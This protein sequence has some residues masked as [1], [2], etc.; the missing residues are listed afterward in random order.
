MSKPKILEVMEK[1]GYKVFENKWDLNIIGVRK[2]DGTPNKFDDRI[3]VVCKNDAGEWQEWS[4]TATTDPGTYWMTESMNKL[5]TAILK[6]GQWRG[7]WKLGLHK[8]EKPALVQIKP[9]TVYRDND[10]DAQHDFNLGESTGIYGINIHRAGTNST[11]VDKWSAGCQ[12]F[13]NNADFEQFLGLCNKQVA[14]GH[15]DVFSYTLLKEEWL[16]E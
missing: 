1:K 12:V 7:C 6:E 11:N 16:T 15:G 10:G 2:K 5:G 13:A 14:A 3:Y 4:W 8:G 9:V